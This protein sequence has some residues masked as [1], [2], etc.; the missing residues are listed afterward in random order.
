MLQ[1]ITLFAKIIY[2]IIF[3]DG[4]GVVEQVGSDVQNLAVGDR[5][6]VYNCLSGE[7]IN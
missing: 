2:P 5:V 7:F 4:A 1:S 3:V 6:Y